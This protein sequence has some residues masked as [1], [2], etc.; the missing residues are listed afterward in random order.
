FSLQLIRLPFCSR[1]SSF[2]RALLQMPSPI[3]EGLSFYLICINFDSDKLIQIWRGSYYNRSELAESP[4]VNQS[5]LPIRIE[6]NQEEPL[7][8]FILPL[9]IFSNII[10]DDHQYSEI[11]KNIVIFKLLN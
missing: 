9:E 4:P 3:K 10:I 8:C 1:R 11:Y 5:E 7:K 6:K 2:K